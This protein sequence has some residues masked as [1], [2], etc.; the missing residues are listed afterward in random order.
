MYT[1]YKGDKDDEDDEAPARFRATAGRAGAL[2][3]GP[4][5]YFPDCSEACMS[6]AASWSRSQVPC[7]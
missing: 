4:A 6:S 3:A 2:L 5:G 1:P 7:G